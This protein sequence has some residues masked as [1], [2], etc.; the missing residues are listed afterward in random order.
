MTYNK[1][2]FCIH[3]F[4]SLEV[5]QDGNVKVCCLSSADIPGVNVTRNSIDE[6]KSSAWLKSLQIALKSGVRHS[7]CKYC[8]GEE[9][10]GIE[11]KRTRDT[12]LSNSNYSTDSTD[13]LY[14][15]LK[16]GNLCNLKCRICN[17]YSSSKWFQEWADVRVD[18]TAKPGFT[19]LIQSFK[20]TWDVD[21][22][23]WDQLKSVMPYIRRLDIYGG[24]PL[25]IPKLWELLNFAKSINNSENISLHFNTNGTVMPT[26][27]QL[28]LLASFKEV[29]IQISL[30]D[31]GKRYT[32]QRHP[33]DWEEVKKN[34]IAFKHMTWLKMNANI[35]SSLYNIYYID[36]IAK[37]IHDELG[38]DIYFNQLHHPIEL[39]IVNL[40]PAIKQILVEKMKDAQ[41]FK[42]DINATLNRIATNENSGNIKKFLEQAELHDKYRNESFADT[43]SEWYSILV[44]HYGQ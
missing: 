19:K 33:A 27:A 16:L 18:D 6:I 26:S 39:S 15:D 31:V 24:E 12:D 9:D 30:D 32:Y 40:S 22:K 35:T 25:L 7:N 10:A 2:T 28:E 41:V 8:W 4:S 43:F 1:K 3:P 38:T 29:D 37:T 42:R 36:E 14:L 34:V 21:S 13:I 23:V 17:P 11:S 44:K 20:H 5:K